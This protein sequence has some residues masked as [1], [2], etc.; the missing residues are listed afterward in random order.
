MFNAD[1]PICLLPRFDALGGPTCPPR[2][3]AC[4]CTEPI[5]TTTL[6]A[7]AA[8]TLLFLIFL[9]LSGQ[10]PCGLNG[11]LGPS[12]VRDKASPAWDF[13]LNHLHW[14]RYRRG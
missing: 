11:E 10:H 8:T 7:K 6:I 3:G 12:R 2:P 5:V 13:L 1:E 9:V 14:R 4:A